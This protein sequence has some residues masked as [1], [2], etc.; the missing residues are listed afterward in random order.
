MEIIS[1]N[2]IRNLE[3]DLL[4]RNRSQ[5]LFVKH[6]FSLNYKDGLVISFCGE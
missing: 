1:N 3:S 2:P 4:D 5:E 6:L